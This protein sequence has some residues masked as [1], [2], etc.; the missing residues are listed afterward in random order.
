MDLTVY[1]G[2]KFLKTVEL[3]YSSLLVK[4]VDY[5]KQENNGDMLGNGETHCKLDTHRAIL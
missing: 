3:S 5:L 4:S 1:L 2:N